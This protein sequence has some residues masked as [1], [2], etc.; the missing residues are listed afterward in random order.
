MH[1]P[2][3]RRARLRIHPQQFLLVQIANGIR[4]LF[5]SV[6]DK[7]LTVKTRQRHP[8]DKVFRY[9]VHEMV[10]LLRLHTMPYVKTRKDSRLFFQL[11]IFFYLCRADGK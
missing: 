6:Y 2:F 8:V 1:S 4:Q 10:G 7:D 3:E 11:Q 9:V 5:L